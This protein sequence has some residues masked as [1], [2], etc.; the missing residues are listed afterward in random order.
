VLAASMELLRADKGNV[1]LYD[2]ATN[3]LNIV[4]QIGFDPNLLRQLNDF[5]ALIHTLR[6]RWLK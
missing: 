2:R 6:D 5:F 1:Q 3:K 4:A